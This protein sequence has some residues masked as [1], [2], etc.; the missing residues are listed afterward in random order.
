MDKWTRYLVGGCT[1]VV[2]LCAV[3]ATAMLVRREITPPPPPGT[4]KPVAVPKWRAVADA[5]TSFG[6][7]DGSVVITQF[8]DFQCPYCKRLF[9]AVREV[10]SAHAG[11]IKLVYRHFPIDR[12]HKQARAAAAAAECAARSGKFQNMHDV[13]YEK[14]DS[15]G[16]LSWAEFGRRAGLADSSVLAACM[17]DSTIAARIAADELAARQLNAT[18]TPVV[19]INQWKFQGAPPLRVVDSVVRSL[20]PQD[21]RR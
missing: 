4:G 7:I 16:V 21:I 15:I 9:N 12:I 10:A 20:L 13:L 14:Q 11:R 5:G 2:S 3:T 1:V 18:G 6:A 8:S 17:Q 19:L